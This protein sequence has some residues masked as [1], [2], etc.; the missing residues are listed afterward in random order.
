MEIGVLKLCLSINCAYFVYKL[1]ALVQFTVHHR[2]CRYVKALM[3]WALLFLLS[4][5]KWWSP[6]G[7]PVLWGFSSPCPWPTSLVLQGHWNFQLH[8]HQ[9]M[10]WCWFICSTIFIWNWIKTRFV[11]WS[12]WG[13]EH[14]ISLQN[15]C[16]DLRLCCHCCVCLALSS[17]SKSLALALTSAS[18]IV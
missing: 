10:Y 3:L 1:L 6:W 18:L 17:M 12:H 11:G 9:L 7:R 5:V 4:V 16:T 2:C 15:I 8:T 13:K 14:I